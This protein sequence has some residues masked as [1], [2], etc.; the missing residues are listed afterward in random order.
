MFLYLKTKITHFTVRCLSEGM[1][2]ENKKTT[3]VEDKSEKVNEPKSNGKEI[4]CLEINIPNGT[5]QQKLGKLF[6]LYFKVVQ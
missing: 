2:T 6:W 3:S 4:A 1:K 5:D